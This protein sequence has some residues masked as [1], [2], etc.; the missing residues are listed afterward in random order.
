MTALT[1]YGFSPYIDDPARGDAAK[2]KPCVVS[3][4][5]RPARHG[6]LIAFLADQRTMTVQENHKN[7]SVNY[8]FDDIRSVL[9]TDPVDL[10]RSA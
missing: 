1:G 3:F 2:P 7:V 9:L 8:A 6:K 10:K 5:D 4:F